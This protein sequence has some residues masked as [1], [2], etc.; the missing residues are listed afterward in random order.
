MDFG[1]SAL[2]I[3][4]IDHFVRSTIGLPNEAKETS[5]VDF[6]RSS[7]VGLSDEIKETNPTNEVSPSLKMIYFNLTASAYVSCAAQNYYIDS[8]A[9]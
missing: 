4:D 7:A 3:D 1:L 8:P 9:P 6:M 5:P 2:F